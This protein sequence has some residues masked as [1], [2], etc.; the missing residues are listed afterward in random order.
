[1]SYDGKSMWIRNTAQLDG[2]GVV[3]RVSMDGMNE[4]RWELPT[5]THDLAVI[6]DGKIGLI[7]HASNGC[8]EVLEFDPATGQTTTL[9]NLT[10]AHGALDCHVNYL[11]YS[12]LDDSF[13]ISDW[14]ES[15]YVKISRTGELLWVLNGNSATIAGTDWVRQHG[16]HVLAPD[17]FVIYS[18]G[19]PGSSMPSPVIE[20]QLDE[21]G[22]MATELWRYESEYQAQFG[23]DVQRLDNGNTYVV[24][25]SGGVIQEVN[26]AG[27]LVE[28]LSWSTGTTVSY[29]V[30]RGSLYGGPPPK[31]HGD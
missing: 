25:S 29:A 10:D 13:Y 21:A 28:E 24:Y 22:G 18:N 8:D 14:A 16:I 6:P 4:E 9:F 5:T 15:A 11:A 3:Q 12:A 23:G 27:Q 26:P 31:I 19:E 17:H 30:K 20:F 1:M 7:A 2:S